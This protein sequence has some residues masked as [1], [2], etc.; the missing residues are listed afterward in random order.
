MR[1]VSCIIALLAA[2]I[3]VCLATEGSWAAD[4]HHRYIKNYP[5]G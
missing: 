2:A 3:L 1:R 5:P 4:Y